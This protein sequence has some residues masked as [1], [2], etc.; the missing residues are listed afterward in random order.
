V[1]GFK[2]VTGH[3]HLELNEMVRD[4]GTSDFQPDVGA[5]VSRAG[6]QYGVPGRLSRRFGPGRCGAEA[7]AGA[8]GLLRGVG[9]LSDKNFLV[10]PEEEVNS[11][12]DGHWY[13]MTPKPIYFTHPRTLAAGVPFE[14]EVPG[15]G[16]VYHLGSRTMC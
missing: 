14:E 2:T 12:F 11:Y 16:T 13:L 6:D 8:E 5:G 1:P 7:A 3:F 10:M 4:R 15:Y 9:K